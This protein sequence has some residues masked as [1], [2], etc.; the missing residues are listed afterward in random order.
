MLKP[1]SGCAVYIKSALTRFGVSFGLA[2]N[3]SAA[4]PATIGVAIDE[5]LR[6]IMRRLSEPLTPASSCG[7]C[8]MR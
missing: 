6:Y 4:V 2:C 8:V 3:I 7:L 1:A 5:P